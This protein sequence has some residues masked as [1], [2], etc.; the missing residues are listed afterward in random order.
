MFELA[1]IH[2][3]LLPFARI[4]STL[5]LAVFLVLHRSHCP[6]WSAESVAV[7]MY[8]LVYPSFLLADFWYFP[9]WERFAYRWQC[10]CLLVVISFFILGR[11]S[12]ASRRIFDYLRAQRFFVGMFGLFAFSC[13]LKL[14]WGDNFN[15]DGFLPIA[16]FFVSAP[17]GC[18]LAISGAVKKMPLMISF[19]FSLFVVILELLASIVYK[20][21][22]VSMNDTFSISM[23]NLPRVFLNTR[24]FDFFALVLA[25]LAVNFVFERY[26]SRG[27]FVLDAPFFVSSASLVL[28]ILAGFLTGGRGVLMCITLSVFLSLFRV[29]DCSSRLLLLFWPVFCFAFSNL[30]FCVIE[31]TLDMAMTAQFDGFKSL[32]RGGSG[33]RWPIWGQW[34]SS[35][36]TLEGLVFGNGLNLPHN[37]WHSTESFPSNPHNIVIELIV[38]G[39]VVLVGILSIFIVK[40]LY[41]FAVNDLGLFTSL[42]LVMAPIFLYS[43]VAAPFEWP[44]GLWAIGL[45]VFSV[46]FYERR[47]SKI[48]VGQPDQA[49][50]LASSFPQMSI[51]AVGALFAFLSVRFLFV[52]QLEL[53]PDILLK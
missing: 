10:I 31:I 40:Y 27:V 49:P 23:I 24:D 51:L 53:I 13:F 36:K 44:S 45:A 46:C 9:L 33:G 29:R 7:S 1:P 20:F 14:F 52:K 6:S 12:R 21:N 30:L 42:C 37:I 4:L 22:N 3:W 11:S 35:V 16:L 43:L 34:L 32:A 19:L 50:V 39:G 8:L 18:Y 48:L 26:S 5:V 41:A 38:K 2:H 28:A 17:L 15:V 25:V 47:S